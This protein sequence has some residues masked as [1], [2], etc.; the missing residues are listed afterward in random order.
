MAF[1][2]YSPEFKGIYTEII[3][4]ALTLLTER[5][6]EHLTGL[7]GSK[8]NNLDYFSETTTKTKLVSPAF[9]MAMEDTARAKG[10]T[11]T[12]VDSIGYDTEAADPVDDVIIRVEDKLSFGSSGATFA[13]GNN[14]SKVKDYLHLVVKLQNSGNV[15]T[16]VFA[17]LIDVPALKNPRSGWDD[18]VTATGK[19]NNGFSSL[20]VNPSDWNC[21]DVIYGGLKTNPKWMHTRYEDV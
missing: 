10:Y 2:D 4:D 17:A 21:I 14:H 11:Y 19:N 20:K 5:L 16:N 8:I 1:I 7:F 15:F 9:A 13:T 18:N 6:D 3:P 12:D